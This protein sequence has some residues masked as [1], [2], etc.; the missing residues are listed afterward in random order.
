MAFRSS[1]KL[2]VALSGRTGGSA[3]LINRFQPLAR[4]LA[5]ALA[6]R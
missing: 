5:T 3:S 1:D 4:A 2:H 6:L